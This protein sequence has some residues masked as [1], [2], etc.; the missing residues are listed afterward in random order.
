MNLHTLCLLD[1]KVKEQSKDNIAKN[2]P[3]Y[4]KS[5]FMTISEAIEQI[6]EAEN[7]H[8]LGICTDDTWCI[9]VSRVGH[10]TQ[11]IISGTLYDLKYID[12]GK[13]LHSL[14]ICAP[15]LHDIEERMFFHYHWNKDK[16]KL[17]QEYLQMKEQR[18]LDEISKRRIKNIIKVS[19]D[20]ETTSTT[21]T[22]STLS[23]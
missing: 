5:K 17:E 9:G 1:I 20:D 4:E 16:K 7:I 6:Y 3:I 2:I 15:N 19:T 8:N 23:Q 21:T 18:R 10:S 13:P 14:V 12:F 11:Q 22:S